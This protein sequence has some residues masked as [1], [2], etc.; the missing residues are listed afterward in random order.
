MLDKSIPVLNF[1][2][3]RKNNLSLKLVYFEIS[4]FASDGPKIKFLVH[5]LSN[6]LD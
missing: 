4:Q 5:A 2:H 3:C 1:T 6:P